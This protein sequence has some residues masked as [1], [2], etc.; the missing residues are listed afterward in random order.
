MQNLRR[1]LFFF[2][3]CFVSSGLLSHDVFAQGNSQNRNSLP[4]VDS[5]LTHLDIGSILHQVNIDSIMRNVNADSIM[6]HINIDSIMH[7][8]NIDSI[9][10]R[11]NIDSLMG[12][13]NLDSLWKSNRSKIESLFGSVSNSN[14]VSYYACII[15]TEQEGIWGRL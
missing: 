9:M 10:S 12:R 2:A 4:N 15:P 3:L 6:H 5:L 14:S 11:V 7:R 13:V 1:I 8:V